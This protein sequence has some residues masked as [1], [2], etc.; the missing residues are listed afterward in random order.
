MRLHLLACSSSLA[1]NIELWEEDGVSYLPSSWRLVSEALSQQPRQ[2][3]FKSWQ[4]EL[5]LFH[6]LVSQSFPVQH[7]GYGGK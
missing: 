2:N 5:V 6:T 7:E 4:V 1:L 3:C